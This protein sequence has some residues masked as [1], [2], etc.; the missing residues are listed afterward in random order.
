MDYRRIRLSL[1]DGL[2]VVTLAD[3]D[4]LNAASLEMV[5]ELRHAF[6]RIAGGETG[7]RAVL[8]TGE[9]R[10]FCSG[11]NLSDPAAMAAPDRDV[12]AGLESHHHPFVSQLREL[13]LPLVT[14]V[15]GA[16][17]GIGCSY[18][19]MGDL[20]V[21]AESAY[22]LQAFRRVGLVP[23]GGA[24]WL[25]PR[26]AGKARA[27]EMMLLGD[28]IDARTALDWGLVNR[29]VADDQLLP[30]ARALACRLA[31]GPTAALAA[32]RRL[33]WD[34]Y[35]RSFPAQLDAERAAQRDAGRTADFV[36]GLQAFLQK[37]EANF[38]GA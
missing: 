14:A 10:G 35:D 18:A 5:G 4:T 27:L 1:E 6:G 12:G 20:I 32:A 33:V 28:R 26:I 36:E 24:T 11:A 38:S 29:V 21:A 37:R 15:N 7:A 30:A 17:A 8:M 25:L 31:D 3:P 16:A 23:D 13:P 19:L 9:G 22:F 34:G 2:A